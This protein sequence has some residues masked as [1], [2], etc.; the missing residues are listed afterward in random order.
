MC[1]TIIELVSS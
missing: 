1:Y